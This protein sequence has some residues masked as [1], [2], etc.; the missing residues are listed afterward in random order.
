MNQNENEATETTSVYTGESKA[1]SA[2]VTPI[3]ANVTYQYDTPSERGGEYRYSR[4]ANPTARDLETV[5]AELEGA[6]HASVFASGMAAIDSVFSLL[7]AGDHI[8][9]GNSLYAE[10]HDL[11]SEFY[12]RYNID[13]SY[14]DTTDPEAVRNATRTDTVLVYGESPSNPLLRITDISAV[15]AA[16]HEVDAL[17]AVDNTFASPAL[18]RP[19]EIGA[20]IVIESL[21][22]YLSGHSDSIGG[23]VATSNGS[24][25][26]RFWRTKYT[27]GAIISPFEAF[28]I[29]RGIKTLYARIDRHCK[30]A[31]L[32]ADL[33]S[34]HGDVERV[35]YPGLVSHP[36]HDLAATQMD[37]FGGMIAF[38]LKGGVED[39]VSFVSALETITIAESL[40]GVESLVE[41]P[42]A[43][44]HQD[45]SSSELTAAGIDEGLVR[46]STGIEQSNHLLNDIKRG[47][48]KIK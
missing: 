5:L 2:L 4:M 42:A 17:L 34:T 38:E 20:D 24:L 1:H 9:A 43:M 26:E 36:S 28:L 35:F 11:L 39:A 12:P 27:R 47:L 37:D 31:T 46:L 14:V 19:I 16:A 40:G 7:S 29:R 22:K 45:L 30:N 44:T 8:V 33:L 23:V 41:V 25:A 3:Y 32:I 10:T 13:V 48:A 21:T 15:A 6:D 18:Q